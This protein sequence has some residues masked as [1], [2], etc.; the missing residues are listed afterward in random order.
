[1]DGGGTPGRLAGIAA[2]A[3]TDVDRDGT[4]EVIAKAQC[5]I[6]DGER[7]QVFALR[8]DGAGATPPWAW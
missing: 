4:D 8:P 6:S 7:Y 3:R 2:V 5:V 1:M